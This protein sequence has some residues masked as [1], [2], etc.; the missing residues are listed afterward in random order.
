VR[1]IVVENARIS[2]GA[3]PGFRTLEISDPDDPTFVVL[4]PF[5]SL[6]A[7]QVARYLMEGDPDPEQLTHEKTDAKVVTFGGR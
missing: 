5:D 1:K 3:S 6:T 4:C 7:A 2:V